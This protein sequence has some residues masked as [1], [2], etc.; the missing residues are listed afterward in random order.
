[1]TG[2]LGED[3]FKIITLNG[4]ALGFEVDLTSMMTE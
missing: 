1:M 2:K 4:N 3:F